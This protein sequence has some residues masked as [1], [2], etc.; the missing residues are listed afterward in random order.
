MNSP[1]ELTVIIPAHNPDPGRLRR[2]LL[3]MRAQSLP[4]ALPH[5]FSR[6]LYCVPD[7]F[8]GDFRKQEDWSK[9]STYGRLEY[10][11]R[12]PH[13]V[14]TE[15][16]HSIHRNPIPRRLQVLEECPNTTS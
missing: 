13:R 8:R 15:E 2:T 9:T 16:L 6:A 12:P 11:G 10:G 7:G 3:G 4:A 1:T 5:S 14:D